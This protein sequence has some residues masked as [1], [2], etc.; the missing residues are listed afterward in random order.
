MSTLK[1]YEYHLLGRG[2]SLGTVAIYVGHLKRFVGWLEKNYGYT[3][4]TRATSL[5][6]EGYKRYLTNLGKKS[7]SVN[8]V[9]DALSSFFKWAVKEGMVKADPCENIRRLPVNN[10]SPKWLTPEETKM[11]L[12]TV[13]EKGTKRD[14]ALISLM[15]FCGLRV[16]EAVSLR[17][18][19]IV[20]KNGSGT[21][22]VRQGKGGKYREVPIPKKTQGIL[23]DYM[24]DNYSKWLFPGKKE[25][26]LTRRSAEKILT[27]YA[28]KTG[29]KVAPV[30]LRHT[31]CKTLTN[32]GVSLEEI[33][34]LAGHGNINSTAR[35][36]VPSFEELQQ[37]V[38]K[39]AWI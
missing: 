28:Q 34:A 33:A 18:N 19:D 38:E 36:T 14:L 16:S 12:E 5:Q 21:V 10:I 31:F 11:L 3:D 8:N 2:L 6:V 24:K 29:L 26:P 4:L 9:I 32:K 17:I 7:A 30:N 25:G 1:N 15:L 20:I 39:I 23:V 35:Y 22:I 13:R 27:K 37:A